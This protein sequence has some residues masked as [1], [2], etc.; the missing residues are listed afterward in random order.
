MLLFKISLKTLLH[1][2]WMLKSRLSGNFRDDPIF[3][4]LSPLS[5]RKILNADKLCPVSFSIRHFKN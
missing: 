1:N 2:I 4:F 5:N 3:D